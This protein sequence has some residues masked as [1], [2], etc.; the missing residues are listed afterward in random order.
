MKNII[1][2]LFIFIFIG[3]KDRSEEKYYQIKSEYH[4]ALDDLRN[5]FFN[6]VTEEEK[7]AL[8]KKMPDADAYVKNVY[9]LVQNH[10]NSKYAVDAW[11]EL[12]QTTWYKNDSIFESAIEALSNKYTKN[13]HLASIDPVMLSKN[14][15]PKTEEFIMK[16]LKD[17]PDQKV[18]GIYTLALAQKYT[19]RDK[20]KYYNLEEGLELYNDLKKNYGSV[21]IEYGNEKELTKLGTIADNAIFSLSKMAIGSK[22]SE[23]ISKDLEG[24]E[25]KLSDYLGKVVVLDVWATWCGPCIEMIP[26]QQKMVETLKNEPFQLI[27]ISLDE[28]VATIE[29]FQKK[30][31]MPWVNWHNGKSGGIIED[32]NITQ[33][34]TILIVD[35]EGIIRHRSNGAMSG[36]EL[37]L[38]VNSLLATG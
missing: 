22:M 31:K 24:N 25:V 13:E 3:C 38:I 5:E 32:W 11:V 28:K 37:D 4:T 2:I 6:A 29:K 33:Y 21:E 30:S 35:K 17:N 26:H 7:M 23:V 36:E 1:F 27:S 8:M 19:N 34:P 12:V 10:P 15:N 16:V 14:D 9:T 20:P 18:K